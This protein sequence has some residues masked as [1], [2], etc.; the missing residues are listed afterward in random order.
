MG[1][2]ENVIYFT[3]NESVSQSVSQNHK[4]ETFL[5]DLRV[6]RRFGGG[7]GLRGW[8]R[9]GLTGLVA[10]LEVGAA[11]RTLDRSRWWSWS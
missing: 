6:H 3:F 2:M 10:G 9:L 4:P 7:G 8:V 1:T 5:H 11:W